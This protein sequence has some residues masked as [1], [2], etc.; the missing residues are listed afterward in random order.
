VVVGR[1]SDPVIRIE[2]KSWI[3]GVRDSNDDTAKV[4]LRLLASRQGG[5]PREVNFCHENNGI[6]IDVHL[7][8]LIIEVTTALF[9]NGIGTS[10]RRPG[11]LGGKQIELGVFKITNDLL[12][13]VAI[14][15]EKPRELRGFRRK[16]GT[17]MD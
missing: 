13:N 12:Y 17:I 6:G 9:R 10:C 5:W 16:E 4:V 8:A 1:V 15:R 7:L 14:T 11:A 2:L 3:T